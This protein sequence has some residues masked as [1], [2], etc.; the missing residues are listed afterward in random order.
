M[1][2][3]FSA[4]LQSSGQT[5]VIIA[6]VSYGVAAVALAGGIGLFALGRKIDREAPKVTLAPSLS[7][8]GGGLALAG[9]F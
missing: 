4:Q 6:W 3:C 5:D 8:S 7:P 2:N 1:A 9:S